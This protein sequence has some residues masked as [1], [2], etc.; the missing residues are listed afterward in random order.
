[1][2][3]KYENWY[4]LYIVNPWIGD[5][6]DI[7]STPERVAL[8]E[9]ESVTGSLRITNRTESKIIKECGKWIS[10]KGFAI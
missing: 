3:E 2:K 7:I 9:V 10:S 8:L 4:I 1:M 5:I 6:S